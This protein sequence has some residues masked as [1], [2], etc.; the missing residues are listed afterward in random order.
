MTDRTFAERLR[1][2]IDNDPNLSEAGLA[3]KAGLDNSTIRQLLSGKTRNVRVDTAMKIC[4]AL[5]ITIEEFMGS[6]RTSEERDILRLISQLPV[7]LRRQLLGYG[8]GLVAA[9]DQPLGLPQ[10]D[11][12]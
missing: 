1:A 11:E 5:G 9:Q 2:V 7:H 12:E 8:Q 6:P 10:K 4:G 3:T